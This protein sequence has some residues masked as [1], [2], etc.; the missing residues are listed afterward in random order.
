MSTSM[1]CYVYNPKTHETKLV[2][3]KQALYTKTNDGWHSITSDYIG[4]QAQ[5]FRESMGLSHDQMA[6]YLE[7]MH[8]KLDKESI[9]SS[10]W[11]WK[12]TAYGKRM[13]RYWKAK[14]CK[15]LATQLGVP[16][17][18]LMNRNKSITSKKIG[19]LWQSTHREQK[20]VR[21]ERA[22]ER[23]DAQYPFAMH[24]T[25]YRREQPEYQLLIVRAEDENDARERVRNLEREQLEYEI[26]HVQRLPHQIDVMRVNLEDIDINKPGT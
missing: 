10:R 4:N 14:R 25:R 11:Q 21:K 12:R 16:W 6:T 2:E 24:V 17:K 8:D 7:L 20:S 9:I 13:N 19:R 22:L 5:R 3:N 18:T 23:V 26:N 15:R 1:P